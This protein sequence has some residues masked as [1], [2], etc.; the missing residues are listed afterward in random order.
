MRHT[1]Y[2]IATALAAV[3]VLALGA[4]AFA[5]GNPAEA[6]S[7]G[8]GE[9]LQIAIGTVGGMIAAGVAAWVIVGHRE[10]RIQ[11]LRNLG[12]F[13]ERVSG[14]PGWVA[15]PMATHAGG[16]LIAVFGMYWDIATHIDAGRDEGPFANASHYFIL[17]GLGMIFLAG[18]LA[19][20]MPD[21]KPSEAS[22]RLPRGMQ[23]P[24]GGVLIL[25]CSA[26][27]LSAF[28]LDD[29]W[30]R[31]FGQDVTLWGPTHL[32]LFGGA[33]LTVIGGFVL[34]IEGRR[35]MPLE[36]V[37]T[38]SAT[39]LRRLQVIGFAGALLVALSTFQGEFDYA[40]PQ[41][42]LVAHP[43]LLML[44]AA[45]ALT[46][47]RVHLGRGG[48]LL[49]VAFY[50]VVRGI[51]SL[52]VG[53]IFGHTTLHFPL[54]IVEALMVEAVALFVKPER[55]IRFGAIAGAAVG[56]VGL[57]A[58][59]AW[60]YL[61]WTVEWPST[62][63]PEAAIAGFIAAVG[64]GVLGARAGRAVTAEPGLPPVSRWAT[65]LAAL[66]VIGVIAYAVPITKGEPE[67]TANVTL[68]DVIPGT[69]RAVEVTARVEPADA[70]D[71]AHWFLITAWQGQEGRSV[72]SKL[73]EISPG[74]WRSQEPLPVHGTWKTTLRLHRG[75]A[76]EGLAVY[77]PEDK[78]IPAKG[79][80]ATASF[81]RTFIDD[82][83]LLQREQKPGASGALVLFGYLVVLLIAI[84][85]IGSI[86]AG[87]ARL[88]RVTSRPGAKPIEREPLVAAADAAGDGDGGGSERKFV[89][90]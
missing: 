17:L 45:G 64:A 22:I 42:R 3:T 27:A 63:L 48:A 36:D 79:V 71:D 83:E 55:A 4:D 40:V 89:S 14:L 65:P 1:R 43:I 85:L 15:V 56:T 82:K 13:G 18:A 61:W 70:A 37:P 72:V 23:A 59:W 6:P 80:P 24:L 16:L 41:F 32:L 34:L 88:E 28:P 58:E 26:V 66:A 35:A 46:A 78:A 2:L 8:G 50:L 19:C 74:V 57:A 53:P 9:W 81:T 76:V 29:I 39:F 60:S 38:K 84:I 25:I 67:V 87:L 49:A 47:V 44:A 69:E 11:L 21:R 75:A 30:H 90:S 20:A 10:G 12:A 33:A 31:V 62:L 68:R 52:L 5:H 51:L 7:A 73:K 54:Y 77:F 86:V